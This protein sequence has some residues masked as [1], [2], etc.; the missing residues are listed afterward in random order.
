MTYKEAYHI[1][2]M[3]YIIFDILKADNSS[4]HIFLSLKEHLHFI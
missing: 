3:T 2:Q 1:S 4:S